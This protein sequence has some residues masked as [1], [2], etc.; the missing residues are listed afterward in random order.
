MGQFWTVINMAAQWNITDWPE[1]EAMRAA[2]CCFA[3]WIAMRGGE[4]NHEERQILDQIRHHFEIYGESRYSRWATDDARIDEHAARTMERY[5][6]RRTEETRDALKGDTSE[7]IFY[8]FPEA[9]RKDVCKGIDHKRAQR[10]LQRLGALKSEKD[11][12][13]GKARLP[14]AGS[15]PVACYIVKYSAL[16]ADDEPADMEIV[17]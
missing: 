3:A 1:G 17:E 12:F 14:G 7:N 11:R 5:G 6:F 16:C 15:N 4:H 13:T 10:L 9:F 2:D 8:I